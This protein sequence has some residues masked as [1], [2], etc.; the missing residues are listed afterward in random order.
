M[1][2][3]GL[4]T[5]TERTE[6]GSEAVDVERAGSSVCLPRFNFAPSPSTTTSSCLITVAVSQF[7]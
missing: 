5:W 2:A 4:G 1:G 3:V 7:F 6:A